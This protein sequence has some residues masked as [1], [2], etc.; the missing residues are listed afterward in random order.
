MFKIVFFFYLNSNLIK[1]LWVNAEQNNEPVWKACYNRFAI[2]KPN[3]VIFQDSSDYYWNLNYHDYW[4]WVYWMPS[5]I[6]V[7]FRTKAAEPLAYLAYSLLRSTIFCMIF[8]KSVTPRNNY[9]AFGLFFCYL[10]FFSC[11]WE[12]FFV[13]T[14]SDPVSG[15]QLDNCDMCCCCLTISMCLLHADLMDWNS[16]SNHYHR[17]IFS[18]E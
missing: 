18:A 2:D 6:S 1:E 8:I 17:S 14:P 15:A 12:L 16:F 5:P 4:N 13:T 9:F 7:A 11:V 10:F 3:I